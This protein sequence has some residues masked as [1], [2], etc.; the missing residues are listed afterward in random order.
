MIITPNV[1]ISRILEIT[2]KTDFLILISCLLTYE[3]DRYVLSEWFHLPPLIP[4]VIGT[5]LAF[6]I[7]FNTNQAY[8]RWWEGRKIWGSLVNN[9]RTWARGILAYTDDEGADTDELAR[10]RTLMIHRQIA[11]LYALKSALRGRDP[12][13]YHSYL[14]PEEI[15]QVEAHSNKQNA[16][17]MLQSQTLDWALRRGWINEFKFLHLNEVLVALT[18]DMGQAERIKNT[19]FPTTYHSFTRIIIWLFGVLI[20]IIASETTGPWSILIGS[21]V[22]FVFQTTHIIGMSLLNPFEFTSSGVPLNQ[23]TRTIEINLL[24][25]IGEGE[26][27]QPVTPVR[28]EYVM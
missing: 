5:A 11:F 7:G 17:L 24:Q 20:T 16:I 28:G 9:S 10:M 23:I 2:W 3:A 1:R 12:E 22:S 18:E 8:D 13:D 27:P 14:S 15:V 6:F 4:T 21:L 25:M 26:V 19:V